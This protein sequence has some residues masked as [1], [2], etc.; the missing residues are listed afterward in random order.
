MKILTIKTDQP[1]AQI[2]LYVGAI[3]RDHLKW[4]ADRQLATTIH[5]KI[6]S[7]LQDQNLEFDHLDG[8]IVFH[9]PGS[10]T[11]LRIGITVANTL[12]LGLKIPIV[13]SGGQTW[14]LDGI[15]L[16]QNQSTK[17][18]VVPIYGSE[19]HITKPKTK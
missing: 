8:I 14:E 6:M 10:F 12:A 9:G 7:L 16:L 17:R 11:G 4:Q 1:I 5:S 18:L 19:P 13:G 3:K 15:K 2:A